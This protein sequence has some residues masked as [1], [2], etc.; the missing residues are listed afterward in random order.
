MLTCP[1]QS[2]KVYLTYMLTYHKLVHVRNFWPSFVEFNLVLGSLSKAT[3]FARGSSKASPLH[4]RNEYILCFG[5]SPCYYFG[6]FTSN[7]VASCKSQSVLSIEAS[8]IISS[9]SSI[10]TLSSSMVDFVLGLTSYE[11]WKFYEQS[12][13]KISAKFCGTWIKVPSLISS[14]NSFE[15]LKII[16]MTFLVRECYGSPKK[17]EF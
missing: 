17:H 11:H 3:F 16:V 2:N 14:L 6:D 13:G 8:T 15:V 12:F 4:S 5:P 10:R 9:S 7:V 1:T